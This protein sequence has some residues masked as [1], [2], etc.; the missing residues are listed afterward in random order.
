MAAEPPAPA[1]LILEGVPKV[2]FYDGTTPRCPEDICFPS[3]IRALLEFLPDEGYGCTHTAGTSTVTCCTYAYVAAVSGAAWHT[4]WG[5][6]WQ[7]DNSALIYL[8]D[9]PDAPYAR[10]FRSLGY[11][12]EFLHAEDRGR[13]RESMVESIRRGMPVVALGSSDRLRRAW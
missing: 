3:C 12:Y 6:G 11:G 8:C 1:R 9:D 5:E 7:T 10:T 13:F 2:A 4:S